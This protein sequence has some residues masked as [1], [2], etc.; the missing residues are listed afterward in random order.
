VTS[1]PVL[2]TPVLTTPV[3]AR[4]GQA[5][6]V[7]VVADSSKV[8]RRTFARIFTAREVDVLVT[9][10]GIAADDRARLEDEGVEVVLA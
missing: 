4:P 5:S 8:G 2:T 6:Q 3:P 7:V 10:A 1:R 9:D